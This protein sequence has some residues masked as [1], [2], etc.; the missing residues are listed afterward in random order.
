M[1]RAL[2]TWIGSALAR[3]RLQGPGTL[4]QSRGVSRRISLAVVDGLAGFR[5]DVTN[6]GD[7]FQTHFANRNRRGQ[8]DSSF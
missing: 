1:L 5:L 7:A 6:A 8:Q 3:R 4:L 2:A